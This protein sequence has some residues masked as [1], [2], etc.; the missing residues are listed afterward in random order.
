[1]NPFAASLCRIAK[2][3]RSGALGDDGGW[4]ADGIKISLQVR[5]R[6]IMR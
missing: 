6:S 3:A 4:L 5:A 1:M 2:H